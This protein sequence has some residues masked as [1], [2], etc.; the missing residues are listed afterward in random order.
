M[1]SQPKS[2]HSNGVTILKSNSGIKP[3]CIE[4]ESNIQYFDFLTSQRVAK[5][6][7]KKEF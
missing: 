4:N 2:I 5:I 3:N 7:K 1:E 6:L